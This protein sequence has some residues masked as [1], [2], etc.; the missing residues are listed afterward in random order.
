MFSYGVLEVLKHYVIYCS[1]LNTIPW[2]SFLYSLREGKSK[3]RQMPHPGKR[4]DDTEKPEDET[5]QR[6]EDNPFW[7]PV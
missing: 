2:S 4:R 5:N 3:K 1:A 7:P 6:K